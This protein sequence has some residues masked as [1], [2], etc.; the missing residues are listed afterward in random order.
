MTARLDGG[1][2]QPPQAEV[3]VPH[4][5]HAGG[6]A[7]DQRHGQRLL[8]HAQRPQ[9]G[10][11]GQATA[12]AEDHH[13]PHQAP[14]GRA[15]LVAG[16]G[17][18]LGDVAVRAQA[19]GGAVDQPDLQIMP[20]QVGGAG[21]EQTGQVGKGL[22]HPAQG[23]AAAGL[24][25]ARGGAGDQAVGKRARPRG[26]GVGTARAGILDDSVQGG[27]RLE[28]APE[29]IPEGDHGR[30]GPLVGGAASLRG[31]PRGEGFERQEAGEQGKNLGH[32]NRGST[33]GAK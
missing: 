11:Q 19:H 14:V 17:K 24:A 5:D 31:E 1:A 18:A 12:G 6:P 26:Q 20:K 3:A 33:T 10:G 16:R 27:I 4:P 28:P 29:Q 15:P 30:P 25:E 7:Q 2:G 22:A 13:H 9:A 32:G 21:A 8:A 23:L